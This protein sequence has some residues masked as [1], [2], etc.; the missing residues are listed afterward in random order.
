[1]SSLSNKGTKC[2]LRRRKVE[3]GEGWGEDERNPKI[4]LKLQ[5]RC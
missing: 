1:M 3:G 2:A 4:G 5:R